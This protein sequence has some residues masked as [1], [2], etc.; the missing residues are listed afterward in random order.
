MRTVSGS[1]S[2]RRRGVKGES[3]P[4]DEPASLSLN[5]VEMEADHL[6]S[7]D[8]QVKRE[9]MW[10]SWAAVSTYFRIV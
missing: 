2:G 6:Q 7:S 3:E 9:G 10:K 8:D 1:S 5:H 4:V